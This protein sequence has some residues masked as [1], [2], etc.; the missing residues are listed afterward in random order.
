M[1]TFWACQRGDPSCCRLRRPETLILRDLPRTW[2]PGRRWRGRRKGGRGWRRKSVVPRAKII[3]SSAL[4]SFDHR[5]SARTDRP[6][7]RAESVIVACTSPE[8]SKL[9]INDDVG[10]CA[11]ITHYASSFP[12]CSRDVASSDEIFVS[13]LSTCDTIGRNSDT[14]IEV[15]IYIY[16]NSNSSEGTIAE[17]TL[18]FDNRES[19]IAA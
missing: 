15:V 1:V 8:R 6:K 18:H 7:T 19:K 17:I 14:N 3:G 12:R 16:R 2:I 11:W 5:T 9:L 10:C 13:I 4:K